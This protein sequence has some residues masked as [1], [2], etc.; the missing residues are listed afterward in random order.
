MMF[1]SFFRR[2][3][4][5]KAHLRQTKKVIVNGVEF[6]IKKVSVEDHAA[7]LNVLLKLHDT[8]KREKPT[9]PVKILEDNAKIKKFMRDFIYAGVVSPKLTLKEGDDA[10]Y[11]HVD[12]L[13]AD[14]ELA[15]KLCYKIIGYSYSK[16]K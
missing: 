6:E 13:L 1:F 12:E 2:K 8:Y 7:G 3:V 14:M 11:I 10:A 15:Q 4:E 16:K 9:D 5:L